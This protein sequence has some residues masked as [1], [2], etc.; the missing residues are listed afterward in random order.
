[1]KL[2]AR[3]AVAVLA[4]FLTGLV[5]PPGRGEPGGGSGLA[6]Y[7]TPT[8]ARGTASLVSQ[9]SGDETAPE[10]VVQRS[11]SGDHLNVAAGGGGYSVGAVHVPA[12]P[13]ARWAAARAPLPAGAA[14]N[15]RAFI[16]GLACP[17]AHVCVAAGA[18][19]DSSG[20]SQGLL[21]T[22]HGSS[23]IPAKAPVP[24][25]AAAASGDTLYDVACMSVTVCV[26]TGGYTDSSGN[27][28]G[29]LLS[30][31]GSSWTAVKAP[32]PAGAAANPQV[33]VFDVACPSATVCAATGNY[34][35]SSGNTQ[36]L[37]LTRHGWSWTAVEAPLPAGAAANPEVGLGRAVCPSATVCVITGQYTAASDR[38]G[39][40]QA[41]LLTGHGSSWTAA[42]APM[43]GGSASS[44]L[45]FGGSACPSVTT[46]VV[47][48]VTASASGD[49]QL[50][51]LTG[52]APS[53]TA[54]RARFPPGASRLRGAD[55]GTPV[56]SSTTVCVVIGDYTD[57]SGS[58]QVMLL[59][60]RGSSW[61][62]TKAPLPADADA[63]PEARSSGLACV[64]VTLCVATG[65][66]T[67][68]SGRWQV[69]LLTGHGSSWTTAKAP[70]PAGADTHPKHGPALAL[71]G[72]ICPSASFCM[73]AGDYTDSSGN[74]QGL[75][76]T[77][78]P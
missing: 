8:A 49:G 46:C 70:L 2:A 32:V 67:D 11:I 22:R 29:L 40:W 26:A 59:T 69:V 54:I 64:S 37:L 61:A 53:W 9:D 48:G 31:S 13:K 44:W 60:G 1:M 78:T 24:A 75:L 56:C 19:F 57:T 4:A 47:T 39:H 28:Q 36:G 35:D 77:G 42:E 10:H 23:W 52:K 63:D 5:V 71:G 51:V 66:Y 15:P 3:A 41:L 68:S 25:A 62:T 12:T 58:G 16:S 50:I 45:D 33:S 17:S 6:V 38:L 30:G 7:G 65:R 72:F 73:A 21:L 34:T 14:A 76:L 43:P 74:V 18:Y 20:N 27:W 55:L